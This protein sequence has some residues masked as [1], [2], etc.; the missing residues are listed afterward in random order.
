[1]NVKLFSDLEERFKKTV[2]RIVW[3]SVT[4]TD[5]RGRLRSRILH[6]VWEGSIGW[7]A[8]GRRSPKAAHISASPWVSL[9]YWDQQH[10]QVHV[11]CHAS[12][13]DNLG[14]KRRVWNLFKDTPAPMGYDPSLFFKNSEDGDFGLLKLLPWRI[15]LWSLQE[16]M[17]GTRPTV[18]RP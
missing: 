16:L 17:A 14:E 8:T 4:T 2:G 5:P 11:E 13:E 3:C 15:E 18:W 9:S 10:E 7:I 1:M 6:P 12:W